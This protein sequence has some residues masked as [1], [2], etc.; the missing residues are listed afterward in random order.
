MAQMNRMWKDAWMCALD[1]KWLKC[2]SCGIKNMQVV[3]HDCAAATNG[4]VLNYGIRLLLVSVQLGRHTLAGTRH[5]PRI[6]T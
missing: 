1:F 2:I 3:P 4:Q 5:F 6:Q